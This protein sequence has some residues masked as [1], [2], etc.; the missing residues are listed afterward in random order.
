MDPEQSSVAS[1][2]LA[3]CSVR[4][5]LVGRCDTT[6]PARLLAQRQDAASRSDVGGDAQHIEQSRVAAELICSRKTSP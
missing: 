3:R 6:Y 2:P 4:I 5:M 1:A